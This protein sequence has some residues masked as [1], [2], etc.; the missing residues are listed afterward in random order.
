[1]FR[2]HL[3]G[4]HFTVV[5]DH[6]PLL[7]LMKARDLNGQYARWQVLLQ[8]YDF[9]I[10]HRAGIKHANADTLSRFPRS[11]HR[12]LSGARFDEDKVLSVVKKLN[13]LAPCRPSSL[14]DAFAPRFADL[15]DSG[16]SHVTETSYMDGAMRDPTL[17]EMNPHQAKQR[18][19]FCVAVTKLVKSLGQCIFNALAKA[20]ESDGWDSWKTIRPAIP[21]HTVD[22]SIVG[23]RF[24]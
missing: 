22:T 10:Q 9:T 24:F 20:R 18:E 13:K 16:V 12:D 4:M 11:S 17:D 19:R 21:S 2:H 1:M 3:Y 6:Q 5:T 23:P 15:F 8:E 14:I 7:W